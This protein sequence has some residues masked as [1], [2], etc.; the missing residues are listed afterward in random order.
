MKIIIP[1]FTPVAATF[2][3]LWPF[4]TLEDIVLYSYPSL[5]WR[6][7]TNA[8]EAEITGANCSMML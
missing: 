2:T 6:P 3:T 1:L 8:A 4:L 5:S 7:L